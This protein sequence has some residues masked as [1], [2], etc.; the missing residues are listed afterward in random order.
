MA[1]GGGPQTFASGPRN[2]CIQGRF[3]FVDDSVRR[4]RIS[5]RRLLGQRTRRNRCRRGSRSRVRHRL[6]C[7][8]TYVLIPCDGNHPGVAGCDYS[9]VD[10]TELIRENP[11]P[12]MHE[13]TTP[14][15]RTLRP[16]GR[17]GLTFNPSPSDTGVSAESC[18]KE[19]EQCQDKPG[20][21]CC[22]GLY[23][24]PA[25]DRAFCIRLGASSENI[26]RTRGFWDRVNANKL[27]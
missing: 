6:N 26:S 24:Q 23:C 9:L 7:P 15:P 19:G 11:A 14:T 8:H 20:W 17:R 10:A 21:D 4:R 16:F 12:V 2:R 5:Q 25:S 13:P 22:P 18:R 1:Y 27:E 3:E